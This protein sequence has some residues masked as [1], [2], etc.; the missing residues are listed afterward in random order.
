MKLH[1]SP[2]S[3]CAIARG[4]DGRIDTVDTDPP[5]SPARAT[6]VWQLP[7]PARTVPVG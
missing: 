1:F 7:P 6:E 4:P 2:A 5:V 3:P